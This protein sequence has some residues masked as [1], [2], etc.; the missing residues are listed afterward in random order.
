[1]HIGN[2]RTALYAYLFAKKHDG[3]FILRIEDTDQERLVDNAVELI[4]KTLQCAGLVHDEGPDKGGQYGPYI[5]SERIAIYREHA[6]ALVDKGHAYYC[7]CTKERLDSLVDTSGNRR[8][9]KH[10]LHLSQSEINQK[11]AEGIPHVIRQNVP[12]EGNTSFTDLVFG[13]IPVENKE[14]Q[15]IVLLKSDGFPTYNFANVVDDHLMAISHVF[16][17]MEYISS[18]PVYNLLYKAFDW[19]IPQYVHLPHIMRDKQHKLSKR[20]GDANFED[21]LRKGFL[22]AAILNYVALLGWNPKTEVEKFSISE[23][24]EAFDLSGISKSSAI[25]DEVKLRW[26]NS[27]YMKEVPTETFSAMSAPYYDSLITIPMDRS[28]LDTLLQPRLSVISDIPELLKFINNFKDFD[29]E[30]FE[31]KAAKS[32][33]E[34]AASFLPQL[35]PCIKDIPEW[36]NDLLFAAFEKLTEQ[37]G[38]KKKQTLWAIRIAV[39]GQMSTPGGAS[40]ICTLLGRDTTVQRI[41]NTIQ[42]LNPSFS[43]K[44][45]QQ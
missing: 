36:N 45:D 39:S 41:E 15:D 4:Y 23:L 37:Q 42:R 1:M 17:G 28:M 14:L 3:T 5:Q 16:R 34:L 29:L 24:I 43:G 11:I 35:L 20:D 13:A 30:L 27:L 19:E 9:D 10:C 31:N 32:T 33:K 21:F 25:F 38:L 26:L 18:T 2:L 40:E 6:Q 44:A 7:F 22:P 8:Y 12:E